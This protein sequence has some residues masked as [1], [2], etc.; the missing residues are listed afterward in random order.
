M[1]KD[2]MLTKHT[3]NLFTGDY[4]KLQQYY[5]DIGAA[6]II[7]RVIRAFVNQIEEKG[8]DGVKIDVDI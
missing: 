4:A 7:R 6:T 5:P 3:M 2:E 1:P 8:Q